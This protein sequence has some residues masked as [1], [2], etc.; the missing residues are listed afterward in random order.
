MGLFGGSRFSVQ[1]G[2]TGDNRRPSSTVTPPDQS[3]TLP[4]GRWRVQSQSQPQQATLQM[5]MKPQNGEP[6]MIKP[7]GIFHT[8]KSWAELMR[9][10]HAH[11]PEER[12]AI[13]TAVGMTWNLAC[14]EVN[15]KEKIC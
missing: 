5:K 1:H 15:E 3:A 7:L 14:K 11:S 2:E 13:V 6:N 9:W 10:V 4:R 12:S 8:P